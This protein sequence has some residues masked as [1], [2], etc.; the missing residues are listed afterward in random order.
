M[1]CSHTVVTKGCVVQSAFDSF[2]FDRVV[3]AI[4]KTLRAK[5][6]ALSRSTRLVD[7]LS[8]SGFSR[9]KLAVCLEDLF[10]MELQN[11]TVERF[12]T[13]DDIVSYF[14]FRYFRDVELAPLGV[15]S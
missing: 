5:P 15:A 4:G 9:L 2:V 6:P 8:L 14:S 7:D 3:L 11:D 1:C 12:Q 10:D 13:L